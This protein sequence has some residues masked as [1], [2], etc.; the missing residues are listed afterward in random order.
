MENKKKTYLK[1]KNCRVCTFRFIPRATTQVVC[2]PLC[3]LKLNVLNKSKAYDKKTKELKAGIK[4]RTDHAD[5]AQ[6]SIN[7]YARLRDHA[8]NCISCNNVNFTGRYDAGH[9]LSRGAYP[10]LRFNLWNIHKQCHWNCNIKRSGNQIAYRKRLIKKIGIERVE[11]L[12]GPHDP[13]KYTIEDLKRIKAIFH[14]K[15]RLLKTRLDN[16]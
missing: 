8:D 16:V 9:F 14:K 10:E 15:Y 1:P 7:K 3:A 6:I 13:L 5:D 4:T 12:E 2:S 11:W